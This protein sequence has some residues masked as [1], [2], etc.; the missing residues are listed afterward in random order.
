MVYNVGVMNNVSNVVNVSLK[1]IVVV[2]L[3]NVILNNNGIIFKIVVVVVISI[4][5]VFDIVVFMMVV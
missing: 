5:F 1:I 2:I 4:G 3:L